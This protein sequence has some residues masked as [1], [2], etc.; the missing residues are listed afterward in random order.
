MLKKKKEKKEKYARIDR[1]F[2]SK[3]SHV[4]MV[5]HG[6]YEWSPAQ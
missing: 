2:I 3:F 1:K 6:N 4:V 5:W